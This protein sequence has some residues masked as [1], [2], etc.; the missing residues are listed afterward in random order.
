MGAHWLRRCEE[1]CVSLHA[2]P[3]AALPS[4]K[5]KVPTLTSSTPSPSPARLE[6]GS[7]LPGKV[8]LW[9]GRIRG[10]RPAVP[11]H[12][13]RQAKWC[14]VPFRFR[15]WTGNAAGSYQ[16]RLLQVERTF[17]DV[18]DRGSTPLASILWLLPGMTGKMPPGVLPGGFF[19]ALRVTFDNLRPTQARTRGLSTQDPRHRNSLRS[20]FAPRC[21]G[22]FILGFS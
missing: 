11:I 15:L 2:A 3:L 8:A 7:A 20:E 4:G 13:D 22:S 19:I 1:D 6:V 5:P 10:L 16:D 17:G 9:P 12:A 18:P 21:R 14:V